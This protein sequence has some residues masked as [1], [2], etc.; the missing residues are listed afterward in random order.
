MRKLKYYVATSL[1]G[2][3][4]RLDGSFDCFIMEG[5]HAADFFESF[6]GFDTVLMG[7]NTYE[8][9]LKAGVTSY[10]NMKNYVFSRTMDK[11]PDE[12]VEIVAD[13][14]GEIV[15]KIKSENSDKDVWLCGGGALAGV[16]LE[17]GVIDEVLLKVNPVTLGEGIPVFGD[18]IRQTDMK[19]TSH[20]VYDNGVVLLE[21]QLN[22]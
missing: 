4:A 3:I 6:S 10:P 18:T 2:Y 17:A 20:K 13:S 22:N 9:G 11:S 7:R 12:N 1:D 5:E 15:Q 8:V 14:P 19:L 16:L 21:Y